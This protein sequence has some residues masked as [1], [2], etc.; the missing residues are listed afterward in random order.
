[1]QEPL[2][3]APHRLRSFIRTCGDPSLIKLYNQVVETVYA[4]RAIHVTFSD[5]YI[6]RYTSKETAT[7]G[8]PFKAYLRKHRDESDAAQLREGGEDCM[9]RLYRPSV[10]E[11]QKDLQDALDP[12]TENGIP[13]HLLKRHSALIARY[14][15]QSSVAGAESLQRKCFPNAALGHTS[16]GGVGASVGGARVVGLGGANFP[17]AKTTHAGTGAEKA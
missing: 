17:R 14:G 7:G 16:S 8:T 9:V 5:L 3:E 12:A 11:Y 1:M 13:R 10:E 2:E 6:A 4:F 15:P